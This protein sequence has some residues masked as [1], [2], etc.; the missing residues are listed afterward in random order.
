M[1][2][3]VI[4]VAYNGL[5]YYDDCFLSLRASS[6]P[7]DIIVVDN[8][9]TDGTNAYIKEHFPDVKL[10]ESTE[11]L[12]FGKGNN[13][14]LRYAMEHNCDF[15]FLLNQDAYVES[16][17]IETLVRCSLEHPEYAILSPMHVYPDKMH[18]NMSLSDG[19]VNLS[20]LSEGYYE[21]L[22]NLK[23]RVFDM[24][25]INAAAWLL[26][27]KTLD[28]IGGFCP[29]F[30]HYFEDDDYINRVKYHNLKI[31]LV[32]GI[33]I[34]HNTS[35][36]ESHKRKLLDMAMNEGLYE[37]LNINRE[38]NFRKRKFTFWKNYMRA[39]LKKDSESMKE[40]WVKYQYLK[41][42]LSEILICREL[43]KM[44][45]PHYLYD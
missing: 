22:Y 24:S 16:E 37:Y 39:I 28:I 35:K 20:L 36:P 45:G 15:V 9:S 11:N 29:L 27:R 17:T 25:Y 1:K 10:I 14:G 41:R 3:Y 43:N 44:R 30:R 5:K 34:V 38:I 33:R 23:D 42:N 32:P 19:D 7:V 8:A 6:Y 26:P 31:G 2:I 4:V 40:N 13:I 18:I 12:G 21:G